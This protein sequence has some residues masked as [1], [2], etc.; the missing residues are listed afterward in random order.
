MLRNTHTHIYAYIYTHTHIYTYIHTHTH[1]HLVGVFLKHK[2]V[3]GR[4]LLQ[5][6]GQLLLSTR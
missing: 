4:L 3:C 1:T 6:M 5:N 2:P